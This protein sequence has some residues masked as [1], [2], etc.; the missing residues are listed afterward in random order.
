MVAALASGTALTAVSSASET[1]PY[2]GLVVLRGI[3]FAG[4]LLFIAVTRRGVGAPV[5]KLPGLVVIGVLDT[6][7][8]GLFAIAST[9]G[10]LSV[11]SVIAS[12]YP[13]GTVVL[14]RL[15]LGERILPHQ[16]VGV[17][18]ALTGVA[19]VALG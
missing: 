18:I 2:W 8:T 11:V 14:A 10:Y 3:A 5:A 9:Y 16:N 17:A 12:L 7:A 19:L 6:V 13:I 1:S 4:I 15:M